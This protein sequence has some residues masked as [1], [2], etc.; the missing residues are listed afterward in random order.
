M[1][2]AIGLLLIAVS[3]LA[4]KCTAH[5][6]KR[7]AFFRSPAA[8]NTCARVADKGTSS[9]SAAET[10]IRI[11]G[12]RATPRASKQSKSKGR[13]TRLA[14]EEVP[15][16]VSVSLGDSEVASTIGTG[17]MATLKLEVESVARP[18]R[19]GALE[20]QG[21]ADVHSGS[22]SLRT[23]DGNPA[24]TAEASA[25][26][27]DS[28]AAHAE[29]DDLPGA[30]GGVSADG[31]GA[32]STDDECDDKIKSRG[33][34]RRWKRSYKRRVGAQKHSR[35][36]R[37]DEEDYDQYVQKGVSI[38][39]DFHFELTDVTAAPKGKAQG[40][41]KRSKSRTEPRLLPARVALDLD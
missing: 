20:G 19:T 39:A 16:S 13:H 33:N 26:L 18:A 21:L 12:K 17:T 28:E 37:E 14:A 30:E 38:N 4:I 6:R 29:H 1:G 9:S 3:L 7:P 27:Q 10:S 23:E 5:L 2:V 40:E 25:A 41:S 31:G 8:G 35:L 32:G 36:P 22:S 24:A 34:G 15:E 11:M